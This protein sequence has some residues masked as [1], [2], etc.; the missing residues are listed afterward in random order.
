MANYK[1]HP[2]VLLN[3]FGIK[4]GA[5]CRTENYKR[6]I[7]EVALLSMYERDEI[8]KQFELIIEQA[9]EKNPFYYIAAVRKSLEIKKHESMKKEDVSPTMR[10]ILKGMAL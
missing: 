5:L 1:T 8:E 2:K 9:G 3:I 10:S 6:W 4:G 7:E